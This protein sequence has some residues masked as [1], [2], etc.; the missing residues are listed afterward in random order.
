TRCPSC[1]ARQ[2]CAFL[3]SP[4][5]CVRPLS[6]PALQVA[7]R[8][9]RRDRPGR[10]SV[11]WRGGQSAAAAAPRSLGFGKRALGGGSGGLRLSTLAARRRWSVLSLIPERNRGGGGCHPFGR[12]RER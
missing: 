3:P 4:A 5:V 12:A 2:R 8:A 1:A 11:Y 9:V 6:A 10:G 7:D